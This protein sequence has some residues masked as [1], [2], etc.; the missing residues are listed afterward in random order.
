MCAGY[1]NYARGHAPELAG[2]D[3]F[4]GRIIHPQFWPDDLGYAGKNVVVIG[5]GATAVTLVPELAKQAAQVTMLQRSPTYVVSRPA[6]DGLA[7]WLRTKLRS[8]EHTSELQ[9]TMPISYAVFCLK[10]KQSITTPDIR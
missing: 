1:Y 3:R 10:N 5:S 7:N 6:E 9:S 8:E 4:H 2:A